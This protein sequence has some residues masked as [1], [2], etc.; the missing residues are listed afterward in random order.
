MNTRHKHRGEWLWVL[1][2]LVVILLYTTKAFA[3]A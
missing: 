1:T 3:S 2:V